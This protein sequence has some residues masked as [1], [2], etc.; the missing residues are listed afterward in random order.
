MLWY[1]KCKVGI[2]LS[3]L[4][5]PLTFWPFKMAADWS[6]RQCEIWRDRFHR[7]SSSCHVRPTSALEEGLLMGQ[8]PQYKLTVSFLYSTNSVMI[9]RW[10]KMA[11]GKSSSHFLW[12]DFIRENCRIWMVMLEN[13]CGRHEVSTIQSQLIDPQGLDGCSLTAGLG[14]HWTALI[15][16]RWSRLTEAAIAW[17]AAWKTEYLGLQ[18]PDQARVNTS[19]LYWPWGC[20]LC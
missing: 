10:N 12:R 6:D 11:W 14:K 13:F 7:L 19:M 17:N 4:Q 1:M 5:L 16:P 8:V 3:P 20:F 9:R 2:N 18:L 15:L